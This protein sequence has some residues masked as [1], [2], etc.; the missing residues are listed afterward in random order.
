MITIIIIT[1][2]M[3]TAGLGLPGDTPAHYR[4]ALKNWKTAIIDHVEDEERE[5]QALAILDSAVSVVRESRKEIDGL[6]GQLY[7]VDTRYDATLADYEEVIT[8]ADALLKKT[9]HDLI[10]QRFELQKALTE[11]EWLTCLSAIHDATSKYLDKMTKKIE[12]DEKN[13]AKQKEQLEK[14]P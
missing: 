14:S 13:R 12:K 7:E 9:D 5:E 11:Q 8:S 10:A 4:Q 6:R 2:I 1:S 3:V